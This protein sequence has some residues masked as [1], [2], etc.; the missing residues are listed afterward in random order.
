M[1]PTIRSH[2]VLAHKIPR[3]G[4]VYA[5]QCARERDQFEAQVPVQM[6]LTQT[7]KAEIRKVSLKKS[8]PIG[9]RVSLLPIKVLL[10]NQFP[11]KWPRKGIQAMKMKVVMVLAIVRAI[12]TTERSSKKTKNLFSRETQATRGKKINKSDAEPVRTIHT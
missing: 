5:R 6:T 4:A 12:L 1:T 3:I 8:M 7:Q 9:E 11:K 10:W 2:A